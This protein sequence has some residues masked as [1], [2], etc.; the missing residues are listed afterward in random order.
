MKNEPVLEKLRNRVQSD[1]SGAARMHTTHF[2][3]PLKVLIV[4]DELPVREILA[5][6][7]SEEGHLVETADDGV[8][9]L[10]RFHASHPHVVL[11]DRNMPR[12]NGDQLAAAIKEID[13]QVPVVMVTGFGKSASIGASAVDVVVAK[14]F[15]RM[16]L[17]AAIEEALALVNERLAA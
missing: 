13:P 15:T 7:L 9:G 8:E 5:L 10:E 11:T 3:E 4:E 17:R 1:V 12:M 6:Y 14:P 2:T 16:D